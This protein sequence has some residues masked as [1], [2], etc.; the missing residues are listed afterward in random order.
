MA[1]TDAERILMLEQR[2]TDHARI[3]TDLVNRIERVQDD[4]EEA[5]LGSLNLSRDIQD[6]RKEVA[7]LRSDFGAIRKIGWWLVTAIGGVAVTYITQ[8]IFGGGL[9]LRAVGVPV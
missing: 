6:L 5:R 1:L 4:A 7:G 3:F 2:Q 8:F 9:V